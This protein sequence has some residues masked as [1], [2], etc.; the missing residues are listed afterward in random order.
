M[1][2]QTAYAVP[3]GSVLRAIARQPMLAAIAATARTEGARRESPSREFSPTAHAV[4]N[5][6]AMTIKN[7]AIQPPGGPRNLVR[8]IVADSL[9]RCIAGFPRRADQRSVIRLFNHTAQYASLLRPTRHAPPPR[10]PLPASGS[11]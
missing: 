9:F 8:W 1:P 4:S 11:I 7:Q 2:V 5:M 3:T 10:I 6:P